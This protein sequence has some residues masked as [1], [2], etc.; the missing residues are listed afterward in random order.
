MKGSKEFKLYLSRWREHL[1]MVHYDDLYFMK[2]QSDKK[3]KY[4][5]VKSKDIDMDD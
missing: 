1:K 5:R 3:T 2:L 4:K